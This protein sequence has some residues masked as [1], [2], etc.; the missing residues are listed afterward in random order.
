MI[1]ALRACRRMS[2]VQRQAV[3]A[4]LPR[5]LAIEV[6]LRACPVSA[7]SK[8]LRIDLFESQR[9]SPS[10]SDVAP[11][12]TSFEMDR[13]AASKLLCRKLFRTDRFGLCLR[14]SLVV[15]S[16]LRRH[17]PVVMVGTA[18][19]GGSIAAH[20]WVEVGGFALD[21]SRDYVTLGHG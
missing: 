4:V 17:R 1:H 18:K 11:T 12:F 16:V 10:Q 2:W 13:V 19:R 21:E 5:L 20:A 7:A 15:A 6:A 8:I 9:S 3:M 14:E